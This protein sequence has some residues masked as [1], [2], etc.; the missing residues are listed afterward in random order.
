MDNNLIDRITEMVL[1]RINTQAEAAAVEAGTLVVAASPVVAPKA[2]IGILQSKFDKIRYALLQTDRDGFEDC[3]VALESFDEKKLLSAVAE[4]RNIVLLAPGIGTL[5]AIANGEDSAFLER[6]MLRAVLWDKKVYVLLDFKIPK[7]KRGTF[8]EKLLDAID[9]LVDMGVEIMT[10]SCFTDKKGET[11]SLVTEREVAEAY[12]LK[13]DRV[14]CAAG[15]IVT[16]AAKDRAAELN[17][18]IDR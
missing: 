16:P 2:A 18:K 15:A 12:A 6:A 17:I 10:Y 13:K 5:E 8:F 1:R 14:V 7:F 9:A 4:S 3:G 11:L